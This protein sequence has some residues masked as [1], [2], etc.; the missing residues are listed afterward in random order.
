LQLVIVNLQYNPPAKALDKGATLEFNILKFINL[1][2]SKE[3]T[4]KAIL[5]QLYAYIRGLKTRQQQAFIADI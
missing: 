5:K 4:I 1:T 3:L 2:P